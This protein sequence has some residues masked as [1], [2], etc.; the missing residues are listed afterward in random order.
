MWCAFFALMRI[1]EDES[2]LSLERGCTRGAL[3]LCLLLVVVSVAAI[4]QDNSGFPRLEI[5]GGYSYG[6][7]N[8]RF[9]VVPPSGPS[10]FLNKQPRGFEGAA[11]YNFNKYFGFTGAGAAN[12][13]DHGNV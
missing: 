3:T 1:P 7:P 2:M 13:G 11:T 6:I 12:L 4:A 8:A 9:G 5:Y 10:N